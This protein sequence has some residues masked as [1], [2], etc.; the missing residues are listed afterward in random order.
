MFVSMAKNNHWISKV[1]PNWEISTQSLVYNSL[2]YCL[3]TF[4]CDSDVKSSIIS[5]GNLVLTLLFVGILFA[6]FSAAHSPRL[7][8]APNKFLR[9]CFQEK[10]H[11]NPHELSG[12]PSSILPSVRI[13][14]VFMHRKI[15]L[16][17][18]LIATLNHHTTSRHFGR[19]FSDFHRDDR[20]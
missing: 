15:F 13:G 19:F 4:I 8:S 16:I 1:N 20:R 3:Y 18:W 17:I 14:R 12:R 9:F 2:P 10:V 6:S 11:W 5:N 7:E